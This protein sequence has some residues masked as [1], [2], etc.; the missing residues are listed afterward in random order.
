MEDISTGIT[1]KRSA[2]ELSKGKYGRCIHRPVGTGAAA[3][4][5]VSAVTNEQP[6]QPSKAKNLSL[7]LV[8]DLAVVYLAQFAEGPEPINRFISFIP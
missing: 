5:Q 7:H 3:D 4:K 1:L 8:N 2:N 6:T